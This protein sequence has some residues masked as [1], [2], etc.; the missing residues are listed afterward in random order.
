MLNR[1]Q[2]VSAIFL[3]IGVTMTQT[4]VL[5]GQRTNVPSKLTI[6]S[7]VVKPRQ[8][9]NTPTKFTTNPGVK[10]DCYYAGKR[11][12]EGSVIKGSDGVLVQCVGDKWVLK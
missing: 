1:K 10:T 8:T 5:A 9:N 4:S 3:T 6:K 2:I 7:R 12:S 11:Y